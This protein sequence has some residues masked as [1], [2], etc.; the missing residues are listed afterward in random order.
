[1]NRQVSDVLLQSGPPFA[2]AY[3]VSLV[4]SLFGKLKSRRAWRPRQFEREQ[5]ALAKVGRCER[6][7]KQRRNHAK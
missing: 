4:G 6:Q 2:R 5:P 7:A 1:M 3:G